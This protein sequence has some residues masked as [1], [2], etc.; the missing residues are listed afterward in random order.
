MARWE[1]TAFIFGF[2]VGERDGGEKASRTS[3]PTIIRQHMFIC[4]PVPAM[5]NTASSPRMTDARK[6]W[7]RD[8]WTKDGSARAAMGTP[9]PRRTLRT[10]ETYKSDEKGLVYGLRHG[11]T[12]WDDDAREGVDRVPS[13]G[14]LMGRTISKQPPGISVAFLFSMHPTWYS[15]GKKYCSEGLAIL[16]TPRGATARAI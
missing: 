3:T 7:P 2:C 12:G 6:T 14:S 11:F 10:V 8:M 5:L 1:T 4:D 13:T 16:E 9:S 15:S